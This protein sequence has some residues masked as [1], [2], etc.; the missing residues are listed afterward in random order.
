[1]CALFLYNWMSRI[2]IN[3]QSGRRKHASQTFH[4]LVK[5]GKSRIKDEANLSLTLIDRVTGNV[6]ILYPIFF[7]TDGT[8]FMSK[9]VPVQNKIMSVTNSFYT[10]T[11]TV[12]SH[13]VVKIN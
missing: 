10:P 1:M 2:F 9:Y 5:I 3:P 12:R 4:L 13:L 7:K 8:F 6:F 11:R